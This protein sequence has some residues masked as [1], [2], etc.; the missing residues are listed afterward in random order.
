MP[1]IYSMMDISRSALDVT[2]RQLDTISHNVANVNTPGYSRQEV[3][4]TSR[5]P[6]ETR[7]GFYGRGVQATAVIQHTDQLLQARIT[8]KLTDQE[9]YSS[10]LAQLQRLESMVN[11]ASDTG[12]GNDLTAF[13]N[14]WQDLSNNPQSSALRESLV[15][16]ASNLSERFNTINRDFMA[17]SRDTSSYLGDAVKQVNSISRRIAE[18]NTKIVAAERAGRAANDF[19]DERQRQ[20]DDLA[21]L[22]NVQW[23]ENG[24]GQVSVMAG[25]G[26]TLVQDDYPAASDEDPLTFGAASGYSDNQIIWTQAG[27]VMDHNEISGGRIGGWLKVRDVDVPEAISYMNDLAKTLIGEVNLLHTQGVGQSKFTSVTGTY[28]SLD[29][30]TPLTDEQNTLAFKDLI[31]DGTLDIWVYEAGTQRKYT[32]DVNASDSL[33]NLV[34]RINST[35]GQPSDPVASVV[36]GKKLQLAATGGVEFAFANDTSGVLAA[37][38]IN[39][40]FSGSTTN[41]IAVN[42]AVVSDPSLIAAGRLSADGSHPLGDN[43]NA[44][45]IGELKDSE[46]MT[47]DTETFNESLISWAAEL[48]SKVENTES[49]KNFAETTGNE[50]KNLRD[51]VSG[52]SIDE[53][54]VK[55]IQYQRSYQTAAKLIAVADQ[56]LTTL[57]DLKK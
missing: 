26:K 43:T 46:V 2:T 20:L 37:L 41:S 47:S 45:A 56:L 25:V 44:L 15:Q 17:V 35:L 23:F 51:D 29:S 8:D 30:V 19:R 33:T 11:E 48:G 42:S 38:G 55:M 36:G 31:S 13:F 28:D 24:D 12:L 40:F 34:D 1:S 27:L 50:L 5:Y 3:I 6:E 4:S 16:V 32:V 39:T 21:E 53:E 54:L 18:L 52:V 10:R 22:M 9:F 49:S 57:L 7:E 14:S